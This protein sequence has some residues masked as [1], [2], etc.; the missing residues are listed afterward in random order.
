MVGAAVVT[1]EALDPP[2][3]PPRLFERL[4]QIAGYTWDESIHP[5]HSTYDYWQLRDLSW[6]PAFLAARGNDIL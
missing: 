1:E 4:R 6:R 3:P 5:V 2:P